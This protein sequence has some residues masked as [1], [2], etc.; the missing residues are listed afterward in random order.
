MKWWKKSKHPAIKWLAMAFNLESAGL[1]EL[2]KPY[3]RYESKATKKG[4]IHKHRPT[5]SKFLKKTNRAEWNR[6]YA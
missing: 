6:K 4:H 1:S 3:R 2:A 5:G